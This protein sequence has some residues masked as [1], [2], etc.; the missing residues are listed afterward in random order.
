MNARERWIRCMHFQPV[1]Y[2]PD[3]E[4]GYWDENF[5]VWQEQGLPKDINDN[6]SAEQY[7]D[8]SLRSEVPVELGLSPGFELK[9]IEETNKY[10][11]IIDEDGVKKKIF[12]EGAKGSFKYKH[13]YKMR[14]D[15]NENESSY[16]S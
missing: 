8:F 2:I 7:F 11:I 9:V 10:R 5:K 15:E 16:L 13:R 12:K 1:D 6:E 14:K 4:F 3:E